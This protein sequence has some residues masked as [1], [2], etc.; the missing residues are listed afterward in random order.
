ML[1]IWLK[2]CLLSDTLFG[3]GEGST[4]KVDSEI[5]HDEWGL[6]YLGGRSL[7]GI[8]Q[9]ECANILFALRLQKTKDTSFPMAAQRLFGVPGS[10]IRDQ[11]I[12][13]VG[14]ARL[15]LNLRRAV[16]VGIKRHEITPQQVLE[17]LTTVRRQTAISAETAAARDETLRAMRVILRNAIFEAPLSFSAEPTE[18]ELSL[19]AACVM[20]FRRVGSGRNRG[21][22]EVCA[23]LLDRSL[24]DITLTHYRLFKEEV[25]KCVP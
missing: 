15:P 20:A 25:L 12:M 24:H 14:D 3:R 2:F 7:K 21:C 22:G 16:E 11:S 18:K 13:H 10:T 4:E 1:K 17:S 23:G 5:C 9:E 19:L 6:P 8:L